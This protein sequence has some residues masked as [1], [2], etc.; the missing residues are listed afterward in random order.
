MEG[1]ER[2]PGKQRLELQLGSRLWF[3]FYWL[4]VTYRLGSSEPQKAMAYWGLSSGFKDLL[5]QRPETER[6]ILRFNRTAKCVIGVAVSIG[7]AVG[8]FLSIWV[9]DWLYDAQDFH[10]LLQ[11]TGRSTLV[12]AI[13]GVLWGLGFCFLLANDLY[14][15]LIQMVARYNGPDAKGPE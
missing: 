14:D 7:L 11:R 10:S 6:L 1:Q 9:T 8:H 5:A 15:T 4:S 2:R 3:H 13:L 12:L